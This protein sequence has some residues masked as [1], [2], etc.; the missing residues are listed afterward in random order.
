MIAAYVFNEKILKMY[1]KIKFLIHICINGTMIFH[2]PW[3]SNPRTGNNTNN[4]IWNVNSYDLWLQL[5]HNWRC[6]SLG[7]YKI[8]VIKK[9]NTFVILKNKTF[10]EHDRIFNYSFH[11]YL[12]LSVCISKFTIS[13]KLWYR[14]MV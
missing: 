4:C 1:K 7:L 9:K 11:I 3:D 12:S 5:R 13:S 14:N 2:K 6:I 8:T 10:Y